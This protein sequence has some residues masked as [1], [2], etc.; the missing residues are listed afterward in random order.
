MHYVIAREWQT[1]TDRVEVTHGADS[2]TP[3][4]RTEF[5]PL[6]RTHGRTVKALSMK[7]TVT[8]EVFYALNLSLHLT[9]ITRR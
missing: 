7:A 5:D 4:M 9:S 6:S 3:L 1:D 8:Q 2:Q